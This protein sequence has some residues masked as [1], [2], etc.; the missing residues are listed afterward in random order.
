[1][2]MR[3]DILSRRDIS[4]LKPSH[5]KNRETFKSSL[6]ALLSHSIRF[7]SNLQMKIIDYGNQS[8][9]IRS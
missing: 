1:M 6:L 9:V 8:D 5:K 2:M 4:D 3:L 7:I